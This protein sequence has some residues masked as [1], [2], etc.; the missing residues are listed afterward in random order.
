MSES[1][2]PLT[3]NSTTQSKLRRALSERNSS[4]SVCYQVDEKQEV[5][6]LNME[7]ISATEN[8]EQVTKSVASFDLSRLRIHPIQR[9]IL[10]SDDALTPDKITNWF[11]RKHVLDVEKGSLAD[12]KISELTLKNERNLRNVPVQKKSYVELNRMELQSLRTEAL[13]KINTIFR[14]NGL[15]LIPQEI[16]KTIEACEGVNSSPK[17]WW[18]VWRRDKESASNVMTTHLKKSIEYASAPFFE[19]DSRKVPILVQRCVH[20]LRENGMKSTGV[21]RVNGSEKRINLLALHFDS[22]P[23]YGKNIDFDG[24]NVNDV[25]GVLKKFLRNLPEPVFPTFLYPY[26]IQCLHVPIFDGQRI[27][28]CQLMTMLLP[29]EHLFL[30]EYLL[31]FFADVAQNSA[32]NN[33]TLHNLARILGCNFLRNKQTKNPV[34]DYEKCVRFFEIFMEHYEQLAIT[35]P[36]L[37]PFELLTITYL[38]SKKISTVSIEQKVLPSQTSSSFSLNSLNDSHISWSAP[39]PQTAIQ[40]LTQASTPTQV[41][42]PGLGPITNITLTSNGNSTITTITTKITSQNPDVNRSSVDSNKSSR[43]YTGSHYSK[44]S[45]G[46]IQQSIF[47]TTTS[48]F[49]GNNVTRSASSISKGSIVSEHFVIVQLPVMH[50]PGDNDMITNFKHGVERHSSVDSKCVKK[51]GVLRRVRTG[52]VKRERV[53]Y[54]SGGHSQ[55][56]SEIHKPSP[57]PADE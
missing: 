6:P 23:N 45:K 30:L 9:D 3:K 40:P 12:S 4:K 38:Q 32:Y 48:D 25:A 26:F 55:N 29:K 56:S 41:I 8:H 2:P 11:L 53:K 35:S 52:P 18:T 14:Q 19:G 27:R 16:L 17:R 34:D 31:P 24:Y 15:R 21:F 1:L 50:I 57:L 43:S 22:P 44:D 10:L 39:L 54:D 46:S 13:S 28:A 33:M 37:H 49:N 51:E 5:L 7:H 42:K 36:D 20:H 47:V